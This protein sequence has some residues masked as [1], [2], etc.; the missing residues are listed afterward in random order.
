MTYPVWPDVSANE[1]ELKQLERWKDERLFH[2]T[3]EERA[4]GPS[5]VFYEGPPTAN[6]RPGIHHVFSRTIKDLVCRFHSMRGESVTRIAGWDTHGL[7]VEIEVEKELKLSGKKDI[8]RFGVEEFNER[9]RK[10]VFKYQAEWENL[11]DRIAYW[12]DYEHPYITCS[13]SYIESVWWLLHRLHE[14]DLLYRGHRV[15]PYCP[16]C[17][18]VLSSHELALGYEDVITNSVYLTFPFQDDP[19]RQLLVWTTTPWTLVSNVAVAVHPDVTYAVATNGAERLGLAAPLLSRVLGEGWEPTGETYRG[20]DLE[21]WIY[22][23]PFDLVDVE[24]AH[25]VVTADYVTTEDGTGLVHLAPAFGADDLAACRAYGLPMVNP[26]RADG[27]FEPDLPLVGGMFFKAADEAL[28]ADLAARDLLFRHVPYEHSYP[29]CWRCHTALLYYAQ[30]SW[31]IRTTAIKDALLRENARTNWHPETVK[32][33][34]YGDWLNNN[35][36]WALSRSRY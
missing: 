32:D 26:V 7:P 16:R 33:G 29:H 8:E 34:R 10:S 1:L 20:R 12:L 21:R 3:L 25:H 27:T 31:Y 35:V 30:P 36:D 18:T 4:G 14:R 9:A 6:G 22:Q 24:G 5:F 23:R 11:S 19:S 17:G 2:R 28:V 13:N 15:L